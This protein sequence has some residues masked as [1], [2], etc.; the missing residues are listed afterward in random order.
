MSTVEEMEQ[1]ALRVRGR[2]ETVVPM[3]HLMDMSLECRRCNGMQWLSALQG[4]S[5]EPSFLYYS[6][7]V[8]A[9]AWTT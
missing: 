5:L 8:F 6:L 2:Q 4:P 7:H 9:I 1:A 3:G